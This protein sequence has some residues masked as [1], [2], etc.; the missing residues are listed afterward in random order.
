[1]ETDSYTALGSLTDLLAKSG[2]NAPIPEERKMMKMDKIR[3][4]WYLSPSTPKMADAHG[5]SESEGSSLI[6]FACGRVFLI[7]CVVVLG[8]SMIFF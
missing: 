4:F 2:K 1:M 3:S 8:R 7:F 5:S 6:L